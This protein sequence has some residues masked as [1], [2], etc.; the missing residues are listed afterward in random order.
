MGRRSEVIPIYGVGIII[1]KMKLISI[2]YFTE[3]LAQ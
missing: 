1:Q 2:K 3:C